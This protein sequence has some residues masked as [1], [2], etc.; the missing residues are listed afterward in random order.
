MNTSGVHGAVAVDAGEV[1]H[2]G[3]HEGALATIPRQRPAQSLGAQAEVLLD[4]APLID[5]SRALRDHLELV[6]HARAASQPKRCQ[7]ISSASRG[8][9]ESYPPRATGRV[10][11][12][13]MTTA[14]PILEDSLCPGSVRPCSKTSF[15]CLSSR[16]FGVQRGPTARMTRHC[17]DE[18]PAAGLGH[19]SLAV[20]VIGARS[21][22]ETGQPDLVFWARASNCAGSA[23]GTS[24]T[25]VR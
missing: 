17:V 16:W 19:A 22:L 25:T 6:D 20:I 10:N 23:P 18:C 8:S 4:A 12:A 15:S 3:D 21:T 14:S 5:R 24:A 11:I 13:P 7:K 9:S 2:A 1:A